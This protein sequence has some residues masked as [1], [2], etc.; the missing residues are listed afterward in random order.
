V[1]DPPVIVFDVNETLSDLS[2]LG[3]RFS[4]IGLSAD[5]A[6]L[7]FAALLRDGFALAASGDNGSFSAIGEDLLR[8]RLARGDAAMGADAAVAHVL[9]GFRELEPH[10]DVVAAVKAL[11]RHGCRLVTLSNGSTAV[12]EGLFARAG[13]LDD[14]EALLSVEDA[15]AWKPARVAYEYAARAC[16]VET[17][18][19][20]LV[21]VHPWD[22]HGAN[23]A[24]LR[25][26]WIN[27]AD[28]RYPGYFSAP[29]RTLRS[30]AELP[31]VLTSRGR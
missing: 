18:Q 2:P 21:A 7:W 15:G 4:E 3:R 12:A 5:E 1:G 22:I 9:E 19:L 16:Q 25:T 29:I 24:G 11:R 31:D 8:V 23:A 27:R 14:F 6:Q 17:E 13:I 30:L 28:E 10:R 20:T 26:V